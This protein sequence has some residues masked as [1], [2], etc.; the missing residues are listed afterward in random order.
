M[1]EGAGSRPERLRDRATSE[2][3]FFALVARFGARD[4]EALRTRIRDGFSALAEALAE[5]ATD[6]E[7]LSPLDVTRIRLGK[8]AAAL[9]PAAVFRDPEMLARLRA[10]ILVISR[11]VVGEEGQNE[12]RF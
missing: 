1:T 3:A 2:R 5:T 11:E 7:S 4:A 6:G 9:V 8:L 12:S 10:E